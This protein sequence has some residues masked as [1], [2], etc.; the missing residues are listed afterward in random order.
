M[1][2]QASTPTSR[3]PQ[4]R[5][6][7][8]ARFIKIL[9]STTDLVLMSDR[10]GRTLYI[11]KAGREMLGWSEEALAAG[12]TMSSI[13]PGWAYAIVSEHA[14]PSASSLGSWSGETALLT[15]TGDEIPVLQVLLAHAGIDGEVDFFSTICRDISERKQKE[16]EQI[17]WSN[18]YDAA[19][20]ASG[21]VLFDWDSTTGKINYSGAVERVT[22]YAAEEMDGGLAQL[23]SMIHPADHPGFD[24]AVEEALTNHEGFR[25]EF[26]IFR[27]DRREIVLLAQG[28]FFLDRLGRIGRMVGFLSDV[29]AERAYERG[30]Q[31]NQERL[32]QSVTERTHAL[33]QAN[34]EL[35]ESARQQ[36]AVARLGQ[37]ALM[38]ISLPELMAE[39]IEVV[40]IGLQV[41]CVSV[42]EWLPD[43]K[44]FMCRAQRGWPSEH[45]FAETQA[46]A[47]SQTGYT[48]TSGQPVIASNYETETRFTPSEACQAAG[49][50][51]AISAPIQADSGPFGV[52]G[53]FSVK[54]RTFGQED[55]SFLQGV[56]N[57]L[58]AAI[59]RLRADETARRAQADAEAANRAKSDFLS[60]MSHEL[61]TPLNAI[62]GFSQLLEMEEHNERQAESID[63]ISRAGRNLLTLINEV[64]DIARLDSG[65]TQSRPEMVKL[66]PLLA[67]VVSLNQTIALR[68]GVTMRIAPL[69]AGELISKTD[70][71]LLKQVLMNLLSNAVKFNHRDGF[72]TIA[73]AR[74]GADSWR[75]SV[76]D[77]GPGIP[78]EDLSRLFVP[79]ERLGQKEGGTEGGTGL[80]LALCQRLVKA[81]DGRIGVTSEAG[82][83]STFWV[84]IPACDSVNEEHAIPTPAPE[85]DPAPLEASESAPDRKTILYVED[86]LSNY[87]LLERIIDTRKNLKLLSA[88]RGS[89]ALDLAK[90][91]CPS[92]VLLD[93]NLPDITGEDLLDQ[94]KQ[95]PETKHIPVIVVTGEVMSDRAEGLLKKG[96]V[97]I[98]QKPYRVQDFLKSLD[99]HIAK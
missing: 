78:P 50:Q 18:R 7:A 92:L 13:F 38:G 33:E 76:T 84:E 5:D 15:N 95:C 46:G 52:L 96:A 24:N 61:R 79:F 26:R 14:I 16:L 12:T 19:V 41:D 49:V 20:R 57:I 1:I 80:G 88:I 6:E 67:E 81:L 34:A 74:S 9:E 65:R 11:N 64:L 62:L 89:M 56:A 55:V 22:G 8:Q 85:R 75:I 48:L 69:P 10:E 43:S 28:H 39:A 83:G 31:I 98:L 17:E 4:H 21:Q 30:L 68:N 99:L 86:D 40:Q 51:S 44:V 45:L 87:F 3:S 72:A 29:T 91:N 77:T 71:G 2:E 54:R 47:H 60:R 53:A 97:E 35:V 59:E 42:N 27:K 73:V 32:E 25:S 63:H 23:R 93:L 36:E 90:E 66:E 70:H 58:S 82:H 37:R 94:L